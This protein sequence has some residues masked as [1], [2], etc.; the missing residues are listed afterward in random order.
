MSD[1]NKEVVTTDVHGSGSD[2]EEGTMLNSDELRLAQLGYK[3]EF[4]RK[5]GF[6]ESWAATFSSMNFISGI[7]VLFGW[8][9]YTGGPT[10]AFSNWTMVGGLSTIVSLVMA[11]IAATMPVAGGIYY[12]SY[13]LGG[14]RYGPI[15]AWFTVSHRL[16]S[17][18]HKP[19]SS[20]RH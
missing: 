10:P 1:I 14:E 9:M 8:A 19:M 15:L 20:S 13:R 5:L 12:W 7:P 4:Y 17:M 3:Q 6:F 16:S 2:V 11:E 18:L